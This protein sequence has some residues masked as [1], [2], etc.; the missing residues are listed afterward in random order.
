MMTSVYTLHVLDRWMFMILIEPIKA[1]LHLSDTQLGF[2]TGPAF[3]IFSVTAGLV[4]S[5]WADR[6]DRAAITSLA[7]AL[8]SVTVM[9]SVLVVNYMH[10]VL[11]RIAAAIGESGVKPPTFSLVGDYFPGA[12]ERTKALSVYFSGN[13]IGSVIGL[14]V[15]GWLVEEYGWKVALFI[16]GCPGLIL[17][18]IFRATIV[19]PRKKLAAGAQAVVLPKMSEVAAFIYRRATC[20]HLVAALVLL[21]TVGSGLAP[22]FGA[23]L[24]RSH[25]MTSAELGVAMGLVFGIGGILGVTIG[26]YLATKVFANREAQ[27]MR[28]SAISVALLGPFLIAF[29][30]LPEKM[31][32]L[33]ALVPVAMAFSVFIGPTYA[34]LQRIVPNDMRATIVALI[35]VIV[36]LI[37]IGVG[38]QVVGLMSDALFPLM[39]KN[40]LRGAMLIVSVL[41]VWSGYHFWQAGKTIKHE[42]AEQLPMQVR[43]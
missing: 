31:H 6:G 16:I 20:R 38:A 33:V 4:L 25:G 27:Q 9:S 22:W 42:L 5:R 14:I 7:V 15:G 3:A 21:Y 11:V 1:D 18:V 8:W 26:G 35:L 29:L 32:A 40:S 17:A 43:S 39:G 30:T 23:F 41:A 13:F 24:V 10:L 34:I 2:V 19:E 12:V 36:N 37:G 28:M